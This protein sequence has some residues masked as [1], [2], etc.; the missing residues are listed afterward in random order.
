MYKVTAPD[1]TNLVETSGSCFAQARSCPDQAGSKGWAEP[2]HKL[3][4]TYLVKCSACRVQLRSS[5]EMKIVTVHAKTRTAC[6]MQ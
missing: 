4:E 1:R 6:I 5:R 2:S 3:K